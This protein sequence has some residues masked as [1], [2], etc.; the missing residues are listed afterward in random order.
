[1]DAVQWKHVKA[2]FEEGLKLE[3][4][5]RQHWLGKLS[6]AQPE[7][8]K[9]VASLLRREKVATANLQV[10]ALRTRDMSGD[11]PVDVGDRLGDFYLE[12]CLGEGGMGTVYR[13]RQTGPISRTVAI[14]IIRAGPTTAET[15]ARF[16]RERRVAALMD[17]PNIAQLLEVGTTPSG[18]PFFVMA[19]VQ[20]KPLDEVGPQ[21]SLGTRLEW[22][23]QVCQAVAFAHERG[24]IHRDLNPSNI[25]VTSDPQPCAKIIDFGIA[26]SL[27]LPGVQQALET[28]AGGLMGTPCY[29]APEQTRG[30]T[31]DVRT[32]IY[33]LGTVLYQ[34]IWGEP[35][36]D[37][38]Q[39]LQ[40]MLQ[41]I[42]QETPRFL[43]TR[44]I[45]KNKKG[46]PENIPRELVWILEK[47]LA[48]MPGERYPSA[49]ALESDIRQLR[50]GAPVSVGPPR[51]S[52]RFGKWLARRR[53]R[54]IPI[55]LGLVLAL[56]VSIW[57]VHTFSKTA[58]IRRIAQRDRELIRDVERLDRMVAAA[59]MAPL[60]H[61]GQER[62]AV[63]EHQRQWL[64]ALDSAYEPGSMLFALGRTHLMLGEDDA[65]VEAFRRSENQGF[66][67]PLMNYYLGLA[68]GRHFW[69]EKQALRFLGSPAWRASQLKVLERRFLE[70]AKVY[71]DHAD[72]AFV[73][74]PAYLLGWKR[75]LAGEYVGA[76][77][78]LERLIQQSGQFYQG[79]LLI[80]DCYLALAQADQ[81]QGETEGALHA[82][83]QALAAYREANHIARSDP[84][85]YQGVARV[86]AARMVLDRTGLNEAVLED[87]SLAMAGLAHAR[88]ILPEDSE[89]LLLEGM[90]AMRAAR[91]LARSGEDPSFYVCL[92]QTAAAELRPL[93]PL[94]YRAHHIQGAASMF[95]AIYQ[96]R[97]GLACEE[98][99][100]AAK[101]TFE[102]AV[103]AVPDSALALQGLADVLVFTSHVKRSRG[104][105]PREDI[106]AATAALA[107]A[108]ILTPERPEVWD[109]LGQVY[110]QLGRHLDQT[111]GEPYNAYLGAIRAGTKALQLK[112][113]ATFQYNCGL[114]YLGQTLASLNRECPWESD[115]E[116]AIYHFQHAVALS[117]NY[118]KAHGQLGLAWLNKAEQKALSGQTF[119]GPLQQAMAAI[120]VTISLNPKDALG[121]LN[122]ARCYLLVGEY[123]TGPVRNS[124]LAEGESL[125]VLAIELNPKNA[126]AHYMFARLRADQERW[127]E[128]MASLETS[129]V[130][131]PREK[132]TARRDRRFDALKNHP[133]FREL[134]GER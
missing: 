78:E 6:R 4:E 14:K 79:H 116:Q 42:Q 38:A 109:A 80:G 52:Y 85:G 58:R 106:E 132:Q 19:Y 63:L 3:G 59:K 7:I 60:H 35:P 93:E 86:L 40:K 119:D 73:P 66:Q 76:I 108:T 126:Y 37:P 127:E 53:K 102:L 99:L 71:L 128:A 13:A 5:A 96:Y 117:P 30:E 41:Q 95:L 11:F 2:C 97:H 45:P 110:F 77:P 133:R 121:Y 9:E 55:G 56:L 57:V 64:S 18:R 70:P 68:Y 49:K 123:R 26:K 61:L 10:G 87:A 25:L 69:R 105:D 32:D 22:F 100:E 82:Y 39:Q 65:A 114:F 124:A 48:K 72:A 113:D 90:V 120:H 1:M 112:E 43:H 104:D 46:L 28:K 44:A 34:L 16:D 94:R 24:V 107:R 81:D 125:L 83:K 27:D 91:Y 62:T 103:R 111:G 115:V 20:G 33:G 98:A 130:L 101:S 8:A 88:E 67:D 122:L 50:D 134:V 31:A 51:W 54:L 84:R 12:A 75:F 29:M 92:A 17:H 118:A 129:V 23:L 15:L 21:F 131:N 47:A 36:F 89:T 74:A